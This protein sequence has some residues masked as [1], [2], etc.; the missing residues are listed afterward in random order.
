[1]G[2]K[3]KHHVVELDK[4]GQLVQEL[5][6]TEER[7]LDNIKLVY[8]V[9]SLGRGGALTQAVWKILPIIFIFTVFLYS[10]NH[11]PIGSWCQQRE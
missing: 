4:R 7:Y 8:E 1:M 3:H 5:V 6:H 11:K 10:V 2:K 9:G